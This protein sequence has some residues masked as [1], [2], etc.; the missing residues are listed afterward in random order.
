MFKTDLVSSLMPKSIRNAVVYNFF[1]FLYVKDKTRCDCCVAQ[2]SV[3]WTFSSL[4][5]GSHNLKGNKIIARNPK[6]IYTYAATNA[7]H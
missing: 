5:L 6:L 4:L 7:V 3:F 2:N 1:F